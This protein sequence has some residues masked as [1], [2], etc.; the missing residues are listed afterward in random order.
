[1]VYLTKKDVV[2]A[3]RCLNMAPEEFEARYLYRTRHLIRLRKPRGSRCNFL[4]EVGC[5]I[6]RGKPT[7]CRLFPF[8]PE[9]VERRAAWR[10]TA[11]RCPGTKQGPLIQF[12]T[13]V[14]IAEEMRRAYP[15]M[16]AA[17]I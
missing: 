12:G 15:S 1:M 5:W 9:L 3:A 2:R 4:M 14:E 7:H 11:K 13:V 8:W 17:T 16:Y 6:H 10:A